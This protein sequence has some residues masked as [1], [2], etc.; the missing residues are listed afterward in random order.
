M[1]K[2][3]VTVQNDAGIHARPAS[4]IVKEASRFESDFH[5]HMYGYR[6]NGKSILGL[7]TLAAEKGA[8]LELETEGPDEEEAMNSLVSL[9]ENSFHTESE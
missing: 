2:R 3:K 9:F 6:I 5:I 1:I 7:L 8:E 4:I